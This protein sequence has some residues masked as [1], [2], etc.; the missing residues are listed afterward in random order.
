MG[1]GQAHIDALCF[2]AAPQADLEALRELCWSGIPP[3]LRS[4]CWRL[5]LGYLPP[6][7]ERRQQILSRKRQEY[8]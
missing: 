3:H 5:L 2:A 6:N 7:K 1:R 8:R 4:V